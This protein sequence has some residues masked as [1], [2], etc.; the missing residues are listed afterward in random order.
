MSTKLVNRQVAGLP[1]IAWAE[2]KPTAIVLHETAND[3]N[4]GSYEGD[5]NYM[6]R[7]WRNAFFHAIA[8]ENNTA[9]VHDPE[10]GGAWGSGPSMHAYAIHIELV[11]SSTKA[12]FE[13]AYRNWIGAAKYYAK[14]YDIPIKLNSGN[15][16]HGIYTHKYVTQTFGGTTHQDPD[17]YLARY[18]VTIAKLAKDLGA[19]STPSKPVKPSKKP[20]PNASKTKSI[21][22]YLNAKG[23][24]SSA[25]NRK[26]LASKYGV[27]GYD[28]S[29]KKNTELLNAMRKGKPKRSPATKKSSYSGNSITDYL[30][31]IG[32]NSSY[33]NR[34]KLAKKYGISG[35]KGSVSQNLKLLE[36]MRGGKSP[37]KSKS[38]YVGKRVEAIS[39]AVRFYN[40]PSWS[41]AHVVG[42]VTKGQGFPTIV[43]KVKVGKGHQ[44]KVRN[45]KGATYYITAS[46]KY[47]RVK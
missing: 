43:S 8:G 33:S 28:L 9:V 15:N 35:Y 13:K 34:S 31:S 39:G 12:G 5:I 4:N 1:T 6:A 18:G 42:S 14:K 2:G 26:K 11:R 27:R 46:T 30:K 23:I 22:D 17:A 7:N 40:S 10:I 44:Y 38:N 29:A 20:K 25:T 37:A 36:L 21:V 41:D 3:S 45:S 47:V 16:K 24:S 32:N 19:A